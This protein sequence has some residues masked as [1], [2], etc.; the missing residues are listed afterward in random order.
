[1]AW[2]LTDR[3]RR[4][5]SFDLDLYRQEAN[6]YISIAE[7]DSEIGNNEAAGKPEKFK[8]MNWNKWE[9]SVYIYLDSIV[10]KSGAPLSYVIRKE[11]EEGTKWEELEQKVQ[12]IHTVPLQGFT[13]NLDSKRVLTLLKELCLI[14]EAETWVRN[15]KYGRAMK[16]LQLHYD[17]PDESKRRKE[18]ARSK[19]KNVYY[20]HEGTFTFEKF[21]TNIYDAFHILEKYGEPLFE[22]EKLRLHFS[23]SQNALPEFKLEV[24]IY[25]SQCSTFASAVVY[26]KTVVAR[27]FPDVAKPGR[28]I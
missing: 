8:Y 14:P 21:V 4:G 26:L 16:D 9:E 19:I 2:F 25:R 5:L 1:L 24:L 13:F 28:Y 6:Q 22:E 18:E 23:K 17:G 11:L 27:L 20:K 12:Q 15:I 3:S 7:I 10:G